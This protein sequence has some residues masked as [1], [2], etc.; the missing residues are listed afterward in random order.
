[1]KKLLFILVLFPILLFGQ[2]EVIV[3]INTDAY[4]Q[5]TRWVLH[6][7]SLYG[8][9]IA[10]V[11]YGYYTQGNTSY[12]DTVY[13]SDSLTNITFVIYDSW[14]DGLMSPGSYFVSVCGDTIVNYPN[15]SFTTGLYS[16]RVVPQ[17][18]PNPP[19][20]TCIPA[21]L[22]INLDQF[23]GETTWEIHDSTG[24][25][26]MAGGP[27]TTAP[28]YQPQFENLCLPI[29]QVSLTMYD[30]YGDGLAGSLWGGNDGSYY[31]MQC[32]DTLVYGDVANYGFDTTHVF[33]SDS[34][35]PPQP[36]FGC[37]DLNY[38]E[39]NA[40]ATVDTNMCF[41]PVIF[42][43][44]DS[45][46]FNYVDSANTNNYITSCN[47]TLKLTDLAA[48]GWAG[49][50]LE[51]KQGN[52]IIDTFTLLSGPDTSFTINLSAPE[53]V[54][55]RFNAT[56]NSGLTANQCGFSLVS[57]SGDTTMLFTG[58]FQPSQTIPPFM[59]HTAITDCGNDCIARVYGCMD[60]LAINYNSEANTED[61]TCY[62]NPGCT[63]SA[64]LEYYTQGFI[65]DYDDGTCLTIAV[66]GCMDSTAV[67]FDSLSNIDNGGCVPIILGCM[68]PLA[69][70]Y[71]ALA[72]TPDTCVP[73][74][75]GCTDPTMFNY[76]SIANT[77]DGSC[78]PAIY[79]CTDSTMFNYNP[80]ANTDDGNC[81][82]FISG[83]ADLN[84][85]NYNP[86]V[87]V[88][89]STACN[90]D[91]GCIT[92]PGNPYWLNDECYAWVISI[93]AYC[94][95][96]G[97]DNYCQSQYNYCAFGTPLDIEDIRD[98]QLYIYPNPTKNIVNLVGMYKIN[99]IVYDMK[100]NK[101]LDL[102]DINQIDFSNFENGIYNL[103]ITYNNL[104]INYRIIKI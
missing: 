26:I 63:S 54:Q 4:P 52:I 56:Y 86:N 34:C 87:N 36:I 61:S 55:V 89:D 48:N 11:N 12:T 41:T 7:D 43:C 50:F 78:F 27:Y 20:G 53:A 39:Y 29:G 81:I 2:K 23:Q 77:D 19:P 66:W 80:L 94:C 104:L 64:Y 98:G 88:P 60:T 5:E 93:D 62:Y 102:I 51:V 1:M 45:T 90:Y 57:S 13:I 32:G 33:V 72:N 49:S 35:P 67:N 71:N 70:N 31:L 99:V 100:G 76:D 15:P 10:D 46:A 85:Y 28:D 101:I 92:G 58:G 18:L 74:T 24:T 69:F 25:L 65:A 84:A 8:S 42:G 75:Y 68:N 95:D 17:C 3:H 6:E 97:W 38:L 82:P 91:A 14:G 73:Y 83:C 59:W 96:I 47:Y 21:V 30:S 37:M 44:I 40:L 16:N 9:I 22:N 79:G 103:N